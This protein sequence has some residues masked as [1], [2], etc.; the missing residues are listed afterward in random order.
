MSSP[1]LI[2]NDRYLVL[3]LLGKGGMGAVYRA[4]DSSLK[5]VVAI[6]E[7]IPDPNSPAQTMQH[8]REQ[9]RREAQALAQLAH[10][11][12]PRIFD[13][14]SYDGNEY[15]VMELV[16][17]TNLAEFAQ[18]RGPL[19]EAL[20]LHWAR[21]ILDALVFLHSR[22]IIHRDIKPNNLILTPDE[23]IVLVDF[24]L[25]KLYDP[26]S[27]NTSTTLRGV[28]TPEY[29]PLEQYA[30]EVGRTDPR[31][32]VYGLGATL[33]R[34][35]AGKSP[36]DV[37][38]RLLNP[39][40][41]RPLRELNPTVSFN[42]ATVIEKAMALYPQARYQTAADMQLAFGM[43]SIARLDKPVDSRIAGPPVL[44]QAPATDDATPASPAQVTAGQS[45]LA[46]MI[47]LLETEESA[48]GG[49]AASAAALSPPAP[50]PLAAET[51]PP[52]EPELAV[53][54]PEPVS[55]QPEITLAFDAPTRILVPKPRRNLKLVRGVL[56]LQLVVGTVLEFVRVPTGTFLIGSLLRDDP[57]AQR[58]EMPQHPVELDEYWIGK[59][60][61]SVAQ[62]TVF[63][64]E[65]GRQPPFDY[66]VKSRFPVVNVSWFDAAIFCQWLSETS[67]KQVR[68]PTE[69]EWEKAARG[70]DGRIYP[71]GNEFD[72]TRLNCA[73]G[74]RPG[75][76]PID[77][78]PGGAS[79]YGA[80]DMVGNVWEWNSDWY[81]AF[82]YT[83]TP[84]RSP[85]GPEVGHY[86]ALR[87][88]AWFSDRAHVR[89]AD[90]TNFNPENQY[91]YVGFRCVLLP[92]A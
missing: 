20:V 2:L 11:N 47:A 32:D 51:V 61:V 35:L 91:D 70:T 54:P 60:P 26:N 15:I 40:G 37:H 10:P 12:L 13:Y 90:R 38:A 59:Y 74:G 6:K 46:K 72:A 88:G 41:M 84:S 52:A 81:D 64:S 36:P 5:R 80:L 57:A 78:F 86:K 66:P 87:G 45:V 7:R 3:A 1:P 34:L 58:D 63:T 50:E 39:D 76:T 42:T 17:G 14:F 75:T 9:F 82:Y 43:T 55:S 19:P 18:S 49:T 62:Y 85:Q 31:T 65:T 28:G 22:N 77:A 83:R 27:Q 69:A 79:P 92:E 21:Q 53:P 48:Q 71:W 68:L 16:E 4:E 56:Q 73:E 25:V 44:A 24:G 8:A 33:Y 23:Q 67:G 29:S 30:R 89:A